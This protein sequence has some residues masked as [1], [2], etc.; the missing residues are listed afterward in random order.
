MYE[1]LLQR[2]NYRLKAM[3]NLSMLMSQ[4]TTSQ[5]FLKL[6]GVKTA[7]ANTSFTLQKK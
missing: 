6:S 5:F 3:A 7:Q 4:M 1:Y 2:S